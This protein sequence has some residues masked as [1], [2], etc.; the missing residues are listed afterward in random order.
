[1]MEVLHSSEISVVKR[2]KRRNIPEDGILQIPQ[3]LTSVIWFHIITK[4]T[5]IL[6]NVLGLT[7]ATGA[8]CIVMVCAGLD[9]VH[10]CL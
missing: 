9:T 7:S 8:Y 10:R 5:E 1:M 4:E 3:I 2:A 6:A